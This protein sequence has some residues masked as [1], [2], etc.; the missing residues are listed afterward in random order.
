MR[1]ATAAPTEHAKYKSLDE[2]DQAL[3][4]RY[5]FD[6]DGLPSTL[7]YV[8]VHAEVL[9][10]QFFEWRRRQPFSEPL[11]ASL[12][13]FERSRFGNRLYPA[14][15]GVLWFAIRSK[16]L[17]EDGGRAAPRRAPS[18]GPPVIPNAHNR[19]LL[20]AKKAMR[21]VEMSEGDYERRQAE[22]LEQ[23]SRIVGEEG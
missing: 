7:A 8:S 2:R 13:S 11:Q 23:R 21:A 12:E 15:H 14:A 20:A 9:V 5:A 4:V 16:L 19:A 3:E 18:Q 1:P 17:P 10:E 6:R 22:L